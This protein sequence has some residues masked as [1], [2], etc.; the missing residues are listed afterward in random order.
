MYAGTLTAFLAVPSFETPID[1]LYDLLD[2][3]KYKGYQPI[4]NAGS[5]MEIIFKVTQK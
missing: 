1:S 2:A 3:M 5:I 4:F